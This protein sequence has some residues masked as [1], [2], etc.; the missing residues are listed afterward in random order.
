MRFILLVSRRSIP[1][2][3][4]STRARSESIPVPVPLRST[5]LAPSQASGS[6]PV[7][8][9]PRSTR[10]T[11]PWSCPGSGSIPVAFVFSFGPCHAALGIQI[12]LSRWSFR[13]HPLRFHLAPSVSLQRGQR[14]PTRRH[15]RREAL[16][17]SGISPTESL[18]RPRNLQR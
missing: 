17:L 5:R 6:I 11:P 4:G 1:L 12:H 16:A 2:T 15:L 9:P 13:I 10:L 7:S 18:P 14:G 3:V 8:V